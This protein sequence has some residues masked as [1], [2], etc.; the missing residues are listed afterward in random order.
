ML[1]SA[2][3]ILY[4]HYTVHIEYV[5]MKSTQI[6]MRPTSFSFFSSSGDLLLSIL[7]YFFYQSSSL[8][9]LKL[10]LL[11]TNQ[12]Q[13]KHF[14]VK[15][16]RKIHLQVTYKSIPIWQPHTPYK[17]FFFHPHHKSPRLILH[18]HRPRTCPSARN[19]TLTFE[20]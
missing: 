12:P 2:Y 16:F 15:Y 8:Y 3:S 13:Q 4:V 20:N 18:L 6:G 5:R 7:S 1:F 11:R 10:M 17:L 14:V 9:K 19:N